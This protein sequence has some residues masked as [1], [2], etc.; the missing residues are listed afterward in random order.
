M[1]LDRGVNRGL[2][3][4]AGGRS[5]LVLPARA[6]GGL[7]SAAPPPPG[8][9]PLGPHRGALCWERRE[10]G[11]KPFRVGVE[12]GGSA[13]SEAPTGPPGGRAERPRGREWTP[14]HQECRLLPAAPSVQAPRAGGW[15][16]GRA[17]PPMI[18]AIR[19]APT[20]LKYIIKGRK[21]LTRGRGGRGTR[22]VKPL[23]VPASGTSRGEDERGQ[24]LCSLG[25]G[26]ARLSGATPWEGEAPWDTPRLSGARPLRRRLWRPE[27]ERLRT[28]HP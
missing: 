5:A 25:P 1:G 17:P 4:G 19:L 26:E 6:G 28:R 18:R 10:R 13:P 15:A 27:P 8:P 24:R 21:G 11:V 3:G 22:A 20:L 14:R 12:A 23:C 7:G 9:D 16:G 2:T